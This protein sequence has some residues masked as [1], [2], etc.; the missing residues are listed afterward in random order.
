MGIQTL[1][2]IAPSLLPASAVLE[3]TPSTAV[4]SKLRLLKVSEKANILPWT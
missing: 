2:K 4:V 1:P 3:K